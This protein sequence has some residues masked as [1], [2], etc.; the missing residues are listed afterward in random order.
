MYNMIIQ[1]SGCT[2]D[3]LCIIGLLRHHFFFFCQLRSGKGHSWEERN[4]QSWFWAVLLFADLWISVK[5][6]IMESD[7]CYWIEREMWVYSDQCLWDHLWLRFFGGEFLP[8]SWS[9]M[10]LLWVMFA[11]CMHIICCV[12]TV[13]S[14]W[15]SLW[16]VF[17]IICCLHHLLARI[18]KWNQTEQC[19]LCLEN[20]WLWTVFPRRAYL[21]QMCSGWSRNDT[22]ALTPSTMTHECPWIMN[23]SSFTF[24]LIVTFHFCGW[25][26]WTW[27]KIH[28]CCS[29]L[30]FLF[31][32]TLFLL[33][34]LLLVLLLY[35]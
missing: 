9:K 35:Y 32:S 1:T 6:D 15:Q 26:A 30:M 24:D 29:S 8:H 20:P 25:H 17:S 23:V 4:V 16:I 5:A 13:F 33:K 12:Y 10:C 19:I 22:G 11:G 2:E 18:L 34:F 31:F 27:S 3:N 14:V 21:R 28:R 7:V